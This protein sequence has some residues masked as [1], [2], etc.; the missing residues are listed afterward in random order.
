MSQAMRSLFCRPFVIS[1]MPQGMR[2][3][4]QIS[5]DISKYHKVC[6][7]PEHFLSKYPSTPR[8]FWCICK[9]NYDYSVSEKYLNLENRNCTE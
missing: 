9:E 2:N 3:F 5:H 4:D 7:S 1:K 8:R 6:N